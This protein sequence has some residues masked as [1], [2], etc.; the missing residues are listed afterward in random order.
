MVKNDSEYTHLLSNLHA[1]P[2]DVLENVIHPGKRF[3]YF[4]AFYMSNNPK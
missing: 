4:Y 2:F 1:F 3:H